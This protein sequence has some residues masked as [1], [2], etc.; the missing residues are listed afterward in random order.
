MRKS[1]IDN[2]IIT[3]VAM[4]VVG[5][6]AVDLGK[7]RAPIR[8]DSGAS[9]DGALGTGDVTGKNPD[10][11]PNTIASTEVDVSID[12]L[13]SPNDDQ[14]TGDDDGVL[15]SD[16]P[17]S[18][19]VAGSNDLPDD[20]DGAVGGFEGGTAVADTPLPS[21]V[22]GSGDTVDVALA[23]TGGTGADVATDPPLTWTGGAG[24]S[25]PDGSADVASGGGGNSGGG[26]AGSGGAG[27]SSTAKGGTLG[28]GGLGTAGSTSA[29]AGSVCLGRIGIDA[30]AGLTQ[31]LLAYYP[32]ESASVGLL[33]DQSGNGKA[34]TLVTGTGG[35]VGY[36]FAA[37]KVN[38]A[39]DLAVTNQGYA[40]LPAGLL[41]SACEATIAT[42]VYVNSSVGWQRIFDFGKDSNV[43]MFLTPL[44]T[45]T[46][47]IRFAISVSSN[48]SAH[49]QIIDGQAELPTGVW[50]HVAVV[51]GPS[52]GILYVNGAQAGANAAM[53]FRPADL[54]NTPNNWIGRS[55]YNWDPTFDGNIDEFRV[56]DRALSPAEIQALASGT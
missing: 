34:A 56:Y 3:S 26:S 20:S 36:S 18:K 51:L 11:G 37:G 28:T 50:K 54:G 41:A 2:S 31:G 49:E 30:G 39:L 21:A 12:S 17:T 9:L 29:D 46:D 6:C 13:W 45:T 40:T 33:P 15:I 7:L 55:Q 47:V 52:G 16:G 35:S 38:K 44:N 32:C 14:R 5:G 42:W 43:Y 1:W 10:L 24:G 25:S 8:Q 4:L 48:G 53:T 19:D 22:D 27:G 23:D